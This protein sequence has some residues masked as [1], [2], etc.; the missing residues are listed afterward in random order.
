[1]AHPEVSVYASRDPRWFFIKDELRRQ[2]IEDYESKG[3]GL[4]IFEN[5]VDHF[6]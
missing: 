6:K 2:G 5:I 1:M 3:I 4:K